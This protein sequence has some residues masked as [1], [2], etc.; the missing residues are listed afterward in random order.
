L[1]LGFPPNVLSAGD[2][3]SDVVDWMG[4]GSVDV[5]I[6]LDKLAW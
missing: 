3:E 4:F 6:T 1:V 2:G 5:N